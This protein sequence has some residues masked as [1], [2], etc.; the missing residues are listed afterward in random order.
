MKQDIEIFLKG[1]CV[2]VPFLGIMVLFIFKPVIFAVLVGI[3][4]FVGLTFVFG[5]LVSKKPED[6]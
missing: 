2:T 5:V 3:A 4:I 1:L 6:M